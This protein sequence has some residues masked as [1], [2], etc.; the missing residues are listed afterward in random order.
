MNTFLGYSLGTPY[1]SSERIS[2]YASWA[3]INAD[4]FAILIG[5]EVY[6][7]TLMA[8][9]NLSEEEAK[10]RALSI[11]DNAEINI[12]KVLSGMNVTIYRWNDLIDKK[13]ELIKKK[14][15]EEK[16]INLIFSHSVRSQAWENLGNRLE[17]VGACKN[18]R[19]NH[20]VCLNLDDYVINE[21]AGLITM[22]EYVGYNLEIYPGKDLDI[23]VQIYAGD[24]PRIES[25]LP[26]NRRRRFL[27]LILNDDQ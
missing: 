8:L 4:K 23:I 12:K 7:Y 11:G 5:D 19:C 14:C 16:N 13:Y 17:V 6:K 10:S 25:V 27:T 3:K 24:F 18:S 20:S 9:K 15:Y 26:K 22:S 21:I 1:Y 2:S